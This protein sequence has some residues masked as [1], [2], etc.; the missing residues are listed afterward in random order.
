MEKIYLIEDCNGLKYVGRTTLTLAERFKSHKSDKKRDH[1]CSSRKLDLDNCKITCLDIAE[2]EEEARELEEFYINSIDCVN[3][4]K[5]NIVQKEYDKKWRE[6]NKDK[7]KE[8]REKNRDE[9]N[10]NRREKYRTKIKMQK[11]AQAVEDY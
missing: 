4:M 2:S 10:R 3:K 5:L 8:Y 11:E 9:L 6:K 1:T 7:I